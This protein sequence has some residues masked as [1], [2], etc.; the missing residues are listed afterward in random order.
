MKCYKETLPWI[1]SIYPIYL[2]IYHLYFNAFKLE[3]IN[4]GFLAAVTNDI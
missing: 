1:R 3:N 4:R 2:H